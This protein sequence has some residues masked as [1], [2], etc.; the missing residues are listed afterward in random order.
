MNRLTCTLGFAEEDEWM[1]CENC[2]FPQMDEFVTHLDTL[3]GRYMEESKM[4]RSVVF[5]IC[6]TIPTLAI[7]AP[8]P[9]KMY[10]REVSAII[11]EV[12]HKQAA[13]A[14]LH[15]ENA[16]ASSIYVLR[17]EL[18]LYIVKHELFRYRHRISLQSDVDRAL[19]VLERDQ[20]DAPEL[21]TQAAR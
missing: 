20:E 18:D 3:W 1:S 12:D 13:Y 8:I 19:A 11:R 2:F 4:Q 15:H 9:R 16:Q 17:M 14:S 5:L 6:L 7:A 10:V 21:Y